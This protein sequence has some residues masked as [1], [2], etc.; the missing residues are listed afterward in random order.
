MNWEIRPIVG[1][2]ELL[3]YARV[4]LSAYPAM[5]GP[6]ETMVT[7]L[8]SMVDHDATS[9]FWGVFAGERLLGCMRLLDFEM[10]YFGKTVPAGG[11][12]SVAVD[13]TEKKRGI[14]K[15]IIQFFIEHYQERG[16]FMTML[17]PFRPDFYHQMGYGY[18]PKMQQYC[19]APASLPA[20]N[21]RH[22]VQHL[23]EADLPELR[24][25]SDRYAMT[26]HGFCRRSDFELQGLIRNHAANRTLVGWR[27][28]GRLQGYLAFGFRRESNFVKNSLLIK[29]WLW[30]GQAAFQAFCSFLHSQADQICQIV[31]HTIDDDFHYVLQ[32]VRNGTEHILPHVYHESNTSGVGLMYRLTG[33]RDFLQATDYRNYNGQ[34]VDLRLQVTDTFRPDNAGTYC[35]RFQD[36]HLAIL[37]EMNGGVELGLDIGDFSA[38]L[39]GAVSL[40]SLHRLGRAK[41]EPHHLPGITKLFQ[42]EQRPLCITGF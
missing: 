31:Y 34:S 9:Q 37:A 41:I 23:A 6:A 5:N 26:H 16:A 21:R 29:E 32:D 10:N 35:L 19:F 39:L 30:N 15:A 14:A 25:F 3:A 4:Q 22:G 1:E 11:I 12:G 38:L 2:E 36:G 20:V 28:D 7:R 13:F 17:Y 40:P 24:D 42:V 33:L 18:A 27:Q 8:Q